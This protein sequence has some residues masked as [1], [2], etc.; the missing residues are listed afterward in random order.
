[1]SGGHFDYSQHYIKDIAAEIESLIETNDSTDIGYHYEKETIAK[2]KEAVKTLRK[3]AVM[4]QR[5]DWLV[6][7]DDGEGS[8]HRRWDEE[9][10]ELS[11]S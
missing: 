1:M 3:A 8:F 2:F 5:V 4:A 9:L 11:H 10:N 7:G 6:S